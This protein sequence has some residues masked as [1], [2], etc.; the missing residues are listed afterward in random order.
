LTDIKMLF[1]T[2]IQKYPH[3]RKINCNTNDLKKIIFFNE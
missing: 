2:S 1:G 3:V